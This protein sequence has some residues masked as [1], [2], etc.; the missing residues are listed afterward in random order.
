[1]TVVHAAGTGSNIDISRAATTCPPAVAISTSIRKVVCIRRVRTIPRGCWS[2]GDSVPIY[3]VV[4]LVYFWGVGRR[5][6]VCVG[7]VGGHPVRDY[8]V[9]SKQSPGNS[10]CKYALSGSAG[11]PASE[12]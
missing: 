10:G 4:P 12:G 11:A 7:I 1:M 3:R 6:Y 5:N 8:V 9:V 2:A